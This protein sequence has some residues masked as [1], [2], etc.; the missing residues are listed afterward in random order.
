[1]GL[2]PDDSLFLAARGY[3]VGA[4]GRRL[5]PR[6][7]VGACELR[8]NRGLTIVLLSLKCANRVEIVSLEREK[9]RSLPY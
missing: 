3:L 7:K 6:C 4:Q 5:V 2:P 8:F 9:M 1:V